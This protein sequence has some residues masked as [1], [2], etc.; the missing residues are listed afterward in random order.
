MFN[1]QQS[2]HLK[3]F[4]QIIT[5]ICTFVFSNILAAIFVFHFNPD[6]KPTPNWILYILVIC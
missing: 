2:K 6:N 1:I 5:N 4:M 3:K